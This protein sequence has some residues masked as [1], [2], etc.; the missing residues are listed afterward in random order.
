M[1]EAVRLLALPNEERL[2]SL[3]AIHINREGYHDAELVRLLACH[4]CCREP[5]VR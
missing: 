2:K 5:T 1:L 3:A 4:W